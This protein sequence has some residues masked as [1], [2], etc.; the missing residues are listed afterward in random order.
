M[1]GFGGGGTCDMDDKFVD[2]ACCAS[3]DHKARCDPFFQLCK[4]VNC[5]QVKPGPSRFS[6]IGHPTTIATE[7]S[8][9]QALYL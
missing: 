6:L 9:N 4:A 5:E 3:R 2:F 7:W 1:F 8:L